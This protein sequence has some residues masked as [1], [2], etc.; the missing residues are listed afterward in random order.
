[1]AGLEKIQDPTWTG[2]QAGT[3]IAGFLKSAIQKASGAH[4]A[5]Q[6]W[7]ATFI[8]NVVLPHPVVWSCAIAYGELFVGIGLTIGAF[9]GIAAFFGLFM[10]LNYLLA[11]T[12][13]TNPILF[14]LSIGIILAWKVA[15]YIGLDRYLLPLLGTPWQLGKVFKKSEINS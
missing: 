8:Q 13:S 9:T 14:T 7:Y 2:G 6:G 10:N 11:G 5:V 12:T 1:M 3:A 4:P 15:G